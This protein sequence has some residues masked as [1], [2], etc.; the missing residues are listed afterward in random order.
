MLLNG[1]LSEWSTRRSCLS[2]ADTSRCLRDSQSALLG[3]GSC[4][5]HATVWHNVIHFSEDYNQTHHNNNKP[6]GTTS[7]PPPLACPPHA[8]LCPSE[9]FHWEKSSVKERETDKKQKRLNKGKQKCSLGKSLSSIS[10]RPTIQRRRRRR[11]GFR[12]S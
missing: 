7:T 9:V 5:K 10:K 2:S 1:R 12:Q 3:G 4:C 8:S 6:T 11:G